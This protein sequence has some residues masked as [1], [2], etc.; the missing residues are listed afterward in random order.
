MPKQKNDSHAVRHFKALT[1]KNWINWKRTPV[2]N[3]LELGCPIILTLC[4]FAART[5][6]IQDYWKDFNLD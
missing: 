2:G 6:I 1:R 5:Y 4:M 3:I